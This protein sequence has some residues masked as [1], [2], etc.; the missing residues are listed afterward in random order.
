MNVVPLKEIYREKVVP[1]LK[2]QF[3]YKNVL[4]IPKLEKIII[5][6]GV[7]EGTRNREIFQFHSEELMAIAGQKPVITHA[8]KA[9]SNFKLRKGMPVGIKVTLRNNNMYNF[10]YKLVNIVLPKVR[11][12]RGLNP[13]SFD[14]RGNYAFGLSEQVIF[15]E[16]RVEKVKR[17]QGMDIIIVTSARTN[18]EAKA[19]LE[20]MGMPFKMG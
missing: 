16:I 19:L 6:M 3:S 20:E 14:G 1:T 2:K 11:D 15:P 10:L 12:F 13:N 4:E 18:E 7:G 5:N 9:I 8:K 17:I